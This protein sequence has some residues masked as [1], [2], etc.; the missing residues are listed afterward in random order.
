MES[1]SYHAY[2]PVV[3]SGDSSTYYLLAGIVT[4]AA[5]FFPLA[6]WLSV[7]LAPL[8][9]LTSP[10]WVSTGSLA[11]ALGLVIIIPVYFFFMFMAIFGEIILIPWA[12]LSLPMIGV[13]VTLFIISYFT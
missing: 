10:F 4:I 6:S 1:A 8:V 3:S 7:L 11:N 5:A 13:G 2:F 12:M 9:L